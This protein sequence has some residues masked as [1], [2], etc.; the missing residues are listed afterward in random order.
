ME[1]F[2][3]L[4]LNSNHLISQENNITPVLGI[5]NIDAWNIKL[6]STIKTIKSKSNVVNTIY[7][8]LKYTCDNF[9][10]NDS[11]LFYKNLLFDIKDKIEIITESQSDTSS[12]LWCCGDCDDQCI[13]KQYKIT[14]RNDI[15]I[16][17][18]KTNCLN[19]ALIIINNKS[20]FLYEHQT[21]DVDYQTI[22][23][24]KSG[25]IDDSNTGGF[26]EAI[27]LREFKGHLDDDDPSHIRILKKYIK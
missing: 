5:S 22:L 6:D 3:I 1:Q 2:I 9:N 13:F 21:Y 19:S 10:C 23:I 20:L 12:F 8:L 26:N 18:C 15:K 11:I 7:V 4:I 17:F 27:I 14:G 25:V 24:N 16:E